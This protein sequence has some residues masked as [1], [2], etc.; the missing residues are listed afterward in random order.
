VKDRVRRGVD[1][2]SAIVA[3]IRRATRNA[4][5]GSHLLTVLTEN[6]VWI[7]AVLKPLQTGRI[8][9]KLAVEVF[10]GVA[11]HFLLWVHE[12]TYSQVKSCHKEYL[13]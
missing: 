10:L 3:G 5:M 12:P 11:A 4:V 7:K 13:L 6:A 9:R 8:I 2:V 1:V